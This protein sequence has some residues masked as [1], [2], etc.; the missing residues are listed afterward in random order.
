LLTVNRINPSADFNYSTVLNITYPT[1][2]TIGYT[3]S[4]NGDGDVA[5]SIY[6]NG[7]YV[8]TSETVTLGTGT[9]NYV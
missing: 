4:N 5:Y 1:P 8:G 9:Y 7:T 2:I 3:E 6:R